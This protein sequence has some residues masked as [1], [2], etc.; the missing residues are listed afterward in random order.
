VDG[1][2]DDAWTWKAPRVDPAVKLKP[3]WRRRWG[4]RIWADGKEATLTHWFSKWERYL[5]AFIA[6]AAATVV[7]LATY[8]EAHELHRIG[9]IERA[10]RGHA[11]GR[12]RRALQRAIAAARAAIADGRPLALSRYLATG[13]MV[14]VFRHQMDYAVALLR[15]G[16]IA[17]F[18]D[19]RHETPFVELSLRGRD[20][21]GLNL[22]GANLANADLSGCRMSG[23]NLDAADLSR[24]D[25]TGTDLTGADLTSA[26]FEEAN[27]SGASLAEVRGR[28][29]DF[30]HAVLDGATLAQVSKLTAA[31]FDD[32]VLTRANLFQSRLPGARFVHTNMLL[33][34][35]AEA[36]LTTV[37]K[38]D[39]VDLTGANLSGT[40]L[41]A[42]RC[43]ALW[44]TGATGLDS[45]T[46][47]ALKARGCIFKAYQ[48][49]DLVAPE[50]SAG[51]K[52]QIAEDRSIPPNRR[53]LT[54]LS[55]LKDYYLQ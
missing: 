1:K 28:G 18:N 48:V 22:A 55:M 42:G 8:N 17:S 14:E 15:S 27:L 33:A 12:E 51:F 2:I 7:T 40:Q 23:T 19:L 6:G 21:R 31:R 4:V 53:R 44:L 32:A 41:D 39:R 34:S 47:T 11:A 54:L 3:N 52:A 9:M 13:H 38:L 25:L 26:R 35:L 46:A 50:I 5:L 36:D 29:A 45:A 43:S 37:A 30:T 20:L 16:D 10:V 24:A 49:V